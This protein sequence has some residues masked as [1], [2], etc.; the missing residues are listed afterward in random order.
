MKTVIPPDRISLCL[1]CRGSG[2]FRVTAGCAASRCGTCRG[3]GFLYLPQV[4]VPS[5]STCVHGPRGGERKIKA[6]ILVVG[7]LACSSGAASVSVAPDAGDEPLGPPRRGPA[8]VDTAGAP[9]AMPVPDVLVM[10]A[11]DLAPDTLKADVLASTPDL[12]P[13]MRD[14]AGFVVCPMVAR[15]TYTSTECPTATGSGSGR[16]FTVTGPGAPDFAC[17]RLIPGDDAGNASNWY[18]YFVPTCSQCGAL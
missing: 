18:G 10:G 15:A 11:P 16:C 14:D 1:A 5:T 4:G 8:S 12:V 3:R 13:S 2:R 6:A 7:L 17:H 9:D